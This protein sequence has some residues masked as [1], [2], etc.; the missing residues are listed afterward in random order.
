MVDFM[1]TSFDML[2]DMLKTDNLLIVLPFCCLVLSFLFAL[3]F[4]MIRGNYK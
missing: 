4:R 3:V 1:L 2:F